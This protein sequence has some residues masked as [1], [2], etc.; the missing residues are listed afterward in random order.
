VSAW[1]FVA[2]LVRIASV[3]RHE[4]DIADYVE[5]VVRSSPHL[6]VTRIGDNVVARTDTGAARRLAIVG[7]LDTVP[8]TQELVVTEDRVTGL[9]AADMKGSLAV[10]I[11]EA[12]RSEPR[13]V[14]V[15]FIFYAREEI[16]RQESG[17][18]E[19]YQQ[20]PDLL[21]AD[22]AL[23]A[24]PTSV[25]AELGCQGNVRVVVRTRGV[26]AHAARPFEGVNA[27]HR[28]GQI[29]A[30]VAAYE[31]R[32][33]ILD[34]VRFV[35]QCQVVK[36]QSGVANNVIP[37]T[38]DVTI[39]H[40]FA[41]DRT[42]DEAVAW[43]RHYLN[44][45]IADGDEFIVDDCAPA[46]LPNRANEFIARIIELTSQEPAAKVGWTDVATFSEWGIPA[47]N[48]GAGDPLLAHRSD[49]FVTKDDV[50][51][52]E[53]LIRELLASMA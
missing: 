51:N 17:L 37:D 27:A 19:V 31:P 29:I 5:S 35:E 38:A 23:V 41:P 42:P 16:A 30:R 53:R 15:T 6:E 21:Q 50:E 46:A 28:A 26:R 7:H 36:V 11:A 18:I 47:V 49:E 10:M 33:V 20:R 34:S 2:P 39:N 44:D 3:S 4:A 43:L 14:D 12:V 52:C 22:A 1:D 13:G 32:S 48:L 25:R 40:R 9:G 45:V 8:G 24:E